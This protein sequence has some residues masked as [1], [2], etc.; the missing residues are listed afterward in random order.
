MAHA[1]YDITD[2]DSPHMGDDYHIHVTIV[3]RH[4]SPFD[5]SKAVYQ[6]FES[7]E[8]VAEKR[9]PKI[10]KRLQDSI[11]TD[12]GGIELLDR[13]GRMLIHVEETAT[14]GM[15]GDFHHRLRVWDEDGHRHTVFSGILT[16]IP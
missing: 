6:V 2:E 13:T 9:S 11:S 10:Q 12:T 4:D 3:D 16:I 1:T 5:P 15:T 7:E 8:T 14:N